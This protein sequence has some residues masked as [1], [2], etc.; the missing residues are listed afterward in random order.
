MSILSKD[1]DNRGRTTDRIGAKGGFGPSF[2]QPGPSIINP[3]GPAH[4]T[5]Q[6]ARAARGPLKICIK[7]IDYAPNIT[8]CYCSYQLFD[9]CQLITL[10]Y[11]PDDWCYQHFFTYLKVNGL[12]AQLNF[13]RLDFQNDIVTAKFITK[14]YKEAA[15]R[16]SNVSFKL[17]CIV[18]YN[19]RYLWFYFRERMWT[20]EDR[21]LMLRPDATV[22]S[23]ALPLRKTFSAFDTLTVET[24]MIYIH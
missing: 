1:G 21:S 13:L 8:K 6:A 2:Y 20:K 10:K 3:P 15:K 19:E 22:F 24:D 9:N 16:W 5:A 18:D 17:A 12:L 14:M 4:C 11:L 7:G 23:N